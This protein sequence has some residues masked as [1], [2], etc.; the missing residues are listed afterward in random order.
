MFQTERMSLIE[1]L[2]ASAL[3]IA[4][5]QGRYL[6]QGMHSRTGN[7]VAESFTNLNGAVSRA[8]E[9]LKA[10][11]VIE[12]W[13]PTSLENP[14]PFTQETVAS[15]PTISRSV[16]VAARGCRRPRPLVCRRPAA[17]VNAR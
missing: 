9:L 1:L 8:S 5:V 16:T 3:P 14:W 11:Y 2:Q 10:G 4:A 7:A 13:S 17:L 12:I 6:L 15:N